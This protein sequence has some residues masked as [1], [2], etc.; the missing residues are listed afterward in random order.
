MFSGSFDE[1]LNIEISFTKCKKGLFKFA[2]YYLVNDLN[3]VSHERYTKVCKN[4]FSLAN[5]IEIN[6]YI[7]R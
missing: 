5:L 6:R 1:I 4:V 2:K 7:L 3:L